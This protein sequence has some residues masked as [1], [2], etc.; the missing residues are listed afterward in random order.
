MILP[1]IVEIFVFFLDPKT[2]EFQMIFLSRLNIQK[3]YSFTF[4]LSIISTKLLRFSQSYLI[5]L[6]RVICDPI[7][8]KGKKKK[9][10]AKLITLSNRAANMVH[11]IFLTAEIDIPIYGRLI[12]L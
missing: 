12:C 3:G 8:T 10:M 4:L 1:N 7:G 9:K 11:H 2:L 5:Y 6:E